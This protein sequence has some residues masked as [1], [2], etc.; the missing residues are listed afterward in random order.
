MVSAGNKTKRLS[1]VN[2]STKAILHHH[3]PFPDSSRQINIQER[4]RQRHS[5]RQLF[6]VIAYQRGSNGRNSIVA[7]SLVKQDFSV[8]QGQ[9]RN[10]YRVIIGLNLEN[11]H[12]DKIILHVGI[13]N[14]LNGSNEPQIDSLMQNISHIIEKCQFYNKIHFY[15]WFSI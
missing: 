2:H 3:Q 13:N 9:T 11:S 7:L 8:F 6:L 1:S 5:T 14:L 12:C 4:N 15:F 10:N